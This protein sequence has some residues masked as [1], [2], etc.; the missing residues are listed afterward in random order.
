MLDK[1][2]TTHT[3]IFVHH[4]GGTDLDSRISDDAY[5]CE[6]GAELMI[7]G[8]MEHHFQMPKVIPVPL[9]KRELN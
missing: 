6:C 3:H 1:L 8:S 9:E 5:E 2:T 7:Y 4:S